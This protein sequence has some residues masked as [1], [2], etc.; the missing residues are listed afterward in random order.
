MI[1]YRL[2]WSVNGQARWLQWTNA[3]QVDYLSALAFKQGLI[4]DGH[5]AILYRM[6][7]L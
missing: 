4:T 2:E 3:D 7:E 1:I 6:F 5:K